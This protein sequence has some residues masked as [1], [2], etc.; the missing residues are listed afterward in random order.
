[1]DGCTARKTL[2]IDKVS[3]EALNEAVQ[4]FKYDCW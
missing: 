2:E 3:I 4:Y 1:M